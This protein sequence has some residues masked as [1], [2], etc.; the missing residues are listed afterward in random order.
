MKP[1]IALTL[2]LD[3]RELP[4]KVF[5]GYASRE[6]ARRH[7]AEEAEKAWESFG[8]PGRD[9][10]RLGGVANLIARDGKWIPHLKISQL[11]NHWDQVVGPLVAQHS[12]VVAFRDG[13]LTIGTE[14]PVWATQLTYLIPQLNE[15]IRGS[16]EGLDIRD[17][18]VVGPTAGYNRRWVRNRK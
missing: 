8:K 1:P 3:P 18:R 7:W 9:P 12:H 6:D 2:K 16:L 17:I 5:E 13:V 14:S 11:N 15:K 10:A 4:A